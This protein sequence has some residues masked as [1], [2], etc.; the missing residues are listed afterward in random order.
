MHKKDGT[1]CMCVDFCNLKQQTHKDV[2]PILLANHVPEDIRYLL[3]G[4][5]KYIKSHQALSTQNAKG[6]KAQVVG[7]ADEIY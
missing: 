1:L 5:K 4:Y 6:A 2:Y 7:C 3:P